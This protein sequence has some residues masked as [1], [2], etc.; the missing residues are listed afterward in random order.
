ME[1]IVSLAKQRG[2]I[3]PGSEIYGGLANSWDFGPLGVEL[4]NNL[5]DCWWRPY[6]QSRDGKC[7]LDA[8]VLMNSKTWE[9]SGHI[10][11]FTDPLV[12]CKKCHTRYRADQTND[13]RCAN[14]GAQEFTAPRQF[15]LL[16]KTAIGPVE[17]K[18]A[19][20]FL[21]PEIAQSMFVNFKN[22]LDTAR[23]RLPFGIASVGKAFRNEITP[24]NFIFR[25]L[26][27]DL[28]EFE[29]FIEEKDW[30]K[31]FDY[32]LRE[33]Q[34]WL[35]DL[36]FAKKN[37]RVREHEASERSHYSQRTA[38]IEYNT[39]FGWKEMFGL[40]YRADYDLKSHM[41]TSGQDMRYTNP[42]TGE[43]F[44]P[45]VIE[46]T[47]GLTR[48][49]LA[50]LLESY[51]ED[52]ERVYLSFLPK[53]APYKAAVFPLL[54]NKPELVKKAR[55]IYDDLRQ[56]Y[57]VAWDERG[58]IGKRYYSQDQIG[59]PFTF[60]IDFETLDNDTVTVRDRD[61]A[62]QERVAVREINKYLE[63]KLS[64]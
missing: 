13:E 55:A 29:Y 45:H 52:G 32:W 7:G 22:V 21:R 19:E 20:V 58:N 12:E 2:F 38:D 53:L 63:N 61:T 35:A 36:G 30:Q 8:A 60:T 40:A 37:L 4:K 31:W 46:P 9:A 24:G 47:F 27:F 23:L 6:W 14:C 16:F 28:M 17:A 57:L 64:D 41:E 15:N 54:K 51:R 3:Y 48:L 1:K 42:Q 33:Q 25:T 43:K 26:E 49:L 5:R 44:I 50:V 10:Q 34:G 59:T 11:N 56:S 39:P 18:G 62:K